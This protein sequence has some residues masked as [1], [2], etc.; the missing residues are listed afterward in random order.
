MLKAASL[1]W[2]SPVRSLS[3]ITEMART[4]LRA[5][6]KSQLANEQVEVR[7]EF[8]TPAANWAGWQLVV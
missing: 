3:P 4:S 7:R 5:A 6:G 1:G 2:R 8:W